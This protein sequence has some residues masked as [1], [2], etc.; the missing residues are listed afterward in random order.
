[1]L[2]ISGRGRTLLFVSH[3][4]NAISSLCTKA[5]ELSHGC[6][7]ESS[8]PK[9]SIEHDGAEKINTENCRGLRSV[10]QA[11]SD[12]VLDKGSVSE[13]FGAMRMRLL[14]IAE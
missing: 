13:K 14:W 3:D 9:D 1:M 10:N 5:L 7:M 4:M 2:E 8:P 11:I 6:V 12:Y